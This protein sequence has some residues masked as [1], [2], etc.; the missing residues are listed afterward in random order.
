MHVILTSN[1]I[2]DP[3]YSN[4][5][6]TLNTSTS[7]TRAGSRAQISGVKPPL[8]VQ[9]SIDND[10][11]IKNGFNLIEASIYREGV[12][13]VEED[14]NAGCDCDPQGCENA[15]DCMKAGTLKDVYLEGSAAIFECNQNCACDENCPNKLVQKGRK[16]PLE[17]FKTHNR[18]WGLRTLVALRK[19]E[20]V[21]TYKGE[22]ITEEEASRRDAKRQVKDVYT[23]ALDKFHGDNPDNERLRDNKYV[24]DGE[25][26]GG[27]TRFI[28]HSCDPNLRIFAVSY[29]HADF[30]IYDLAF[31]STED[32]PAR[33]EL[34]FDYTGQEASDSIPDRTSSGVSKEKMTRCLC[35]SENC[36]GVLWM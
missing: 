16:V 31:F 32:V 6:S 9:N 33:T 25:V 7:L 1:Q 21:D 28:N 23:F 4:T 5:L 8:Y 15:S 2:Q 12:S 27:I 34:T 26:L 18:G 14:F 13:L 10:W 24:I 19:G 35:G 22:L 20:F 36:K 17:I 30:C 3:I 11:P 29:N